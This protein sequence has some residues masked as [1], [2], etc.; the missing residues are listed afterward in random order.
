MK[1]KQDKDTEFDEKAYRDQI[2]ARRLID[3]QALKD[4]EE[5]EN[6]QLEIQH[7]NSDNAWLANCDGF[8]SQFGLLKDEEREEINNVQTFFSTMSTGQHK[9]L[10]RV[11]EEISQ[12][13]GQAI[14]L[15]ADIQ[16]LTAK[17]FTPKGEEDN[18]DKLEISGKIDV[19]WA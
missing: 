16:S 6:N 19:L 15:R 7:E 17:Y 14:K 1:A 13:E 4:T 9:L 2:E 10:M 12:T 8:L 5:Y 3:L 18:K 11:R